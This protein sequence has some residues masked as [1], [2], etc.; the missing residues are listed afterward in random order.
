MADAITATEESPANF[1]AQKAL[2]LLGQGLSYGVQQAGFDTTAIFAEAHAI[3]PQ[4]PNA[5]N[6]HDTKLFLSAMIDNIAAIADANDDKKVTGIELYALT[7]NI[8]EHTNHWFQQHVDDP[9]TLQFLQ[10]NISINME[11]TENA[12]IAANLDRGAVLNAEAIRCVMANLVDVADAADTFGVKN[13]NAISTPTDLEMVASALPML[14]S[15]ALQAIG[16]CGAMI[17]VA[18]DTGTEFS[19]GVAH[20]ANATDKAHQR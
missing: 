3:R 10:N 11:R 9:D 19:S 14:K 2:Q 15:A 20:L 12:L 7:G 8:V 4:G 5:I 6:A 18:A 13:D 17:R 1:D 16:T